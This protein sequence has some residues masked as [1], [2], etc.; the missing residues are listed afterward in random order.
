MSCSCAEAAKNQLV[1]TA[2]ILYHNSATCKIIAQIYL[3][4]LIFDILLACR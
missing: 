3:S 2:I 1:K 4:T